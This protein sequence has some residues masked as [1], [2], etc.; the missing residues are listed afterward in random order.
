MSP[1]SSA[2]S[3]CL[4]PKCAVVGAGYLA[5]HIRRAGARDDGVASFPAL[6][7]EFV[8]ALASCLFRSS[9]SLHSKYAQNV[10][11]FN[12]ERMAPFLKWRPI[13]AA[14]AP[15]LIDVTRGS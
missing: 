8:L 11:T 1:S 13:V 10:E 14:E 6:I 3:V 7:S 2:A 12:G 15:V 9:T 5:T 4:G